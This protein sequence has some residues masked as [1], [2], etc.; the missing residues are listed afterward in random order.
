MNAG[1]YVIWRKLQGTAGVDADGNGD[2]TVD[3]L[4]YERWKKGNGL[5]GADAEIGFGDIVNDLYSNIQA[6]TVSPDQKW[7]ATWHTNNIV[8]VTPLINGIPD[9]A[10]RLAFDVINLVG[11]ARDIAFDAAGNLHMVSS[12]LGK[13]IVLGPGGHTVATTSW[14]GSAYAFNINTIPGSG[15]VGGTVPEPGTLVL[16]LTGI[17]AFGFRRR[18]S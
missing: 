1:D 17:L 18:R 4:D 10:N 3:A 11:N 13:Y 6:L 7:L 9:I 2:A 15:S 14:N 5:T 12:G 8:M 16:A